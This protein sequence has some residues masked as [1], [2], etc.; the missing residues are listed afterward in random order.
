MPANTCVTTKNA[1]AKEAKPAS[2]FSH[3]ATNANI[4][5]VQ[6]IT[7]SHKTPRDKETGHLRKQPS[8]L[9]ATNHNINDVEWLQSLNEDI[10]WIKG[11]PIQDISQQ[12]NQNRQAGKTT[13]ELHIVAHGSNG[14]TKL[15]NTLL[16]KQYLEESSELLQGWKLEAIYLWSCEAGLNT[17]LTTAL[18]ECTEADVY[19]SKGRINREQPNIYSKK[20]KTA[21]LEAL[22]GREQLLTATRS[23]ESMKPK[24]ICLTMLLMTTSF[25]SR[26]KIST[27]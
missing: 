3:I 9:I 15:G 19:S 6:H 4:D 14:E 16:T 22:I 18:E 10:T 13:S 8:R 7:S 17:E 20:E 1:H 5:A 11:D 27:K 26:A 24:K 23:T 12:L 21:L 2:Y 25:T